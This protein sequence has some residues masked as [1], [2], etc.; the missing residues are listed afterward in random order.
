MTESASAQ[1]TQEPVSSW[2]PIGH[3]GRRRSTAAGT[4]VPSSSPCSR[5]WATGKSLWRSGDGRDVEDAL[6]RHQLRCQPPTSS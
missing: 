6:R 5:A 4:G 2:S 3:H 1:P